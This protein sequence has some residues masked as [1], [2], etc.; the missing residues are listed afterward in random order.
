[1][2]QNDQNLALLKNNLQMPLI[3][4]DLLL[5]NAVPASDVTYALHEILG[6]Q[7]A[8]QAIICSVMTVQ[9]IA[10]FEG[11]ISADLSFLQMECDRLL[12]R[13][14]ARDEMI[15]DNPEL[16]EETQK[17]MMPVI[18]EDIEGFLDLLNLCH[19]SF[20]ITNP[21]ITKIL[22]IITTQ[23]QTQLLII[24]EVIT[25]LETKSRSMSL[26]TSKG[27]NGYMAENVIM[28]PR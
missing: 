1:M 23:L 15:T 2:A 6:N 21:R 24:D 5:S 13:Y 19:L 8:E 16:W 9:E 20:E 26:T 17:D 4:R 7:T 10:V 14:I 25:L 27:I 22:D 11:I 28:F 3:V 12:E 18:A